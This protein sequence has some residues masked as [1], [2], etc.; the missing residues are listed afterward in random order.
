[1][2]C[3]R[4]WKA[5]S[6]RNLGLASLLSFVRTGH[7]GTGRRRPRDNH[8]RPPAG[9]HGDRRCRRRCRHRDGP[10]PTPGRAADAG[11]VVSAAVLSGRGEHTGPC[12]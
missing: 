2:V 3:F 10:A 4:G 5:R 8:Y 12:Q 11:L 1:M 6:R 7:R 9:R